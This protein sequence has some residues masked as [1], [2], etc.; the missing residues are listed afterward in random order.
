MTKD[1]IRD[2]LFDMKELYP[3]FGED[4]T[5][6]VVEAWFEAFRG[7]QLKQADRALK[8]YHA[9]AQRNIAPT[10]GQLL[11]LIKTRAE[12]DR[13]EDEGER[14]TNCPRCGGSEAILY[15]DTEGYDYTLECICKGVRLGVPAHVLK[16]GDDI[17]KD[18]LEKGLLNWPPRDVQYANDYF[19]DKM[20]V[21]P[22]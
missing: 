20:Q 6:F 5:D 4:I 9:D 12:I 7:Y 19:K 18:K 21:L 11:G 1:E 17:F 14:D 3:K 10:A 8:K 2:F 22:F 13:R 16:R 15:V